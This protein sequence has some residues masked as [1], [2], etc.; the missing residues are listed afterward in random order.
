MKLKK[1]NRKDCSGRMPGQPQIRINHAGMIMLNKRFVEKANLK[2]GDKVNIYQDEDKPT[3]WYLKSTDEDQGVQMRDYKGGLVFNASVIARR[4]MESV[5]ITEKSVVFKMG[6]E[7]EN[8]YYAIITRAP[9]V[10]KSELHATHRYE[11]TATHEA[12]IKKQRRL[13]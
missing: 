12:E 3:D 8:G 11:A 1:F 4:I 2:P 13:P 6:T 10:R 7:P 9:K 5:N